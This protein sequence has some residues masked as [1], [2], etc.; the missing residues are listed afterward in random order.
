MATNNA[1]RANRLARRL[2][3]QGRLEAKTGV[4]KQSDKSEGALRDAGWT[5]GPRGGWHAPGYKA[6]EGKPKPGTNY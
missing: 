6:P 3:R 5:Q 1:S 2:I 4:G